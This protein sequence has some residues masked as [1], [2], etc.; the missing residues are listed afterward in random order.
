MKPHVIFIYCMPRSQSAWLALALSAVG[1]PCMHEPVYN[2]PSQGTDW[3]D[4]WID[5]TTSQGHVATAFI[6]SELC[7]YRE[8][9]DTH[10]R[11]VDAYTH[12]ACLL[13]SPSEVHKSLASNTPLGDCPVEFTDRIHKL[14]QRHH[15]DLHLTYPIG[16]ADVLK[17]MRI[18]GIDDYSWRLLMLAQMERMRVTLTETHL[19]Q[20]CDH[21]RNEI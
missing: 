21:A 7:I 4:T 6:G 3:I 15:Y 5:K 9:I 2:I 1:I 8:D 12:H 17:V 10:M 18:L 16:K 19:K 13:R 20:I 14:I 11:N